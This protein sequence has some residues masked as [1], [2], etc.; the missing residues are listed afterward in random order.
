MGLTSPFPSQRNSVNVQ[1]VVPLQSQDGV[2]NPTDGDKPYAL[3]CPLSFPVSYRLLQIGTGSASSLFYAITWM[4][5][6]LFNKHPTVK[7]LGCFQSFAFT[8]KVAMTILIGA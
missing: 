2:T 5:Y 3:P 7:H 8:N 4:S 6:N 1:A